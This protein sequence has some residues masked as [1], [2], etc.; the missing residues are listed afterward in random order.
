VIDGVFVGIGRP[1]QGIAGHAR[2]HG[3]AIVD[4]GL[5]LCSFF[6]V[7]PRHQLQ[8]I[9]L[10]GGVIETVDLVKSL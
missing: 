6:V 2:G 5:N 10:V 8:S 4:P 7:V 3:K 1:V 9:E